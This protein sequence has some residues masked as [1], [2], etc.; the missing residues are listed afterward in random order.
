M[1]VVFSKALD[2]RLKKNSSW[3]LTGLSDE[4]RLLSKQ[5]TIYC[6]RE[7]MTAPLKII[8]PFKKIGDDSW[9]KGGFH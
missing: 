7:K 4:T 2:L 5:Q 3:L 9:K 6:M 1:Y 8:Q